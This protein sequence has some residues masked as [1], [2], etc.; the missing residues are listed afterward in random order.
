MSA[1]E[2]SDWCKLHTEEPVD[3]DEAFVLDFVV[4]AESPQPDDQEPKIIMTTRRLL[5]NNMKK[6]EMVQM[7]GTHKV[8]WQGFPLIVFGT[9]D[10]A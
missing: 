2:I 4:L 8:V 1:K 6:N 3:D 10:K 5:R 7:D 9:T